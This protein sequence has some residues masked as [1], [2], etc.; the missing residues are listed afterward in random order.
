MKIRFGGVRGTRPVS[1]A[2]HARF[3]GD[4]TCAWVEG[5][6]GAQVLLDAG[7]GLHNV[8]SF[9]DDASPMLLL[10]THYHLDHLMG[11]PAFGPLYRRDCVLELAAPAREGVTT[12]DVFKRL[13]AAPFWPVAATEIPATV[14]FID[15]PDAPPRGGLARGELLIRWADVHHRNGCHAYRIDE[16]STGAA[17]VLATDVEWA[18][19][20]PAERLALID[21]CARPTPCDVLAMDGQFAGAN[22]DAFR[23]WGHS[24]WEDA[25]EVARASGAARLLVT[26]HAPTATDVALDALER[27]V[28]S[29]WPGASL[30]RQGVEYNTGDMA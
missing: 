5:A 9:V 10:M 21:L 17:F 16:P 28:R 2:R 7:T 14:R 24:R 1:G 29:A 15:L 22:Y 12:A 11:L 4:T 25:V 20:T 23:G 27:D 18:L 8:E 26:H 30:A 13:F 3:G 6:C 19:S